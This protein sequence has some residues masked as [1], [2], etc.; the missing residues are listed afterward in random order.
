MTF[1]TSITAFTYCRGFLLDEGKESSLLISI[2]QNGM[3]S[4]WKIENRVASLI[5]FTDLGISAY[6]LHWHSLTDRFGTFIL[7]YYFIFC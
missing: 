7:Y 3:A 1:K 5:N 2:S 4:F 6:T